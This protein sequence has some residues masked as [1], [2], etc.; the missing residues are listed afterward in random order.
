MDQ[1]RLAHVLDPDWI[2]DPTTLSMEELRSRRAELQEVEVTLSYQRRMA[3][4]RLDI[5]AAEKQRRDSGGPA[6][7]SDAVVAHLTGILAPNTRGRGTGRL[8]QLMAPD[9]AEAETPELDAI[10]GPD[11]LVSLPT[12]S[13]DDLA[14]LI[15]ELANF[16][17]NCSA[18]RRAVH[19]RIDSLQG[20][21]VRR[22]RS[23]EASVETLLQ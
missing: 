2:G 4:G 15:E 8:S 21:V 22:Y 23:G 10:A 6:M 18:S 3:Q 5:V 13:E 12:M 7:D 1:G 9:P 11:T 19:D 16:E 14:S 20:E 17:A